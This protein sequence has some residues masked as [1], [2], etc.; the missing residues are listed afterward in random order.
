LPPAPG[1]RA[2]PGCLCVASR[3]GVRPPCNLQKK[4]AHSAHSICMI[5][6]YGTWGLCSELMIGS[7]K[8]AGSPFGRQ[9]FPVTGHPT[10]S[11]TN[12]GT[13]GRGKP[14]LSGKPTVAQ[15]GGESPTLAANQHQDRH[16]T[17]ALH[18]F[19]VRSQRLK[20]PCL[21]TKRSGE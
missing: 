8:E 3:W 19:V 13:T 10:S 16:H 4:H 12:S 17:N 2:L 20:L 1:S 21:S 7:C 5:L 15:R 18:S 9:A 11:H 6:M 14:N